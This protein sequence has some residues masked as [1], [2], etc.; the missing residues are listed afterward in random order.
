MVIACEFGVIACEFEVIAC[1]Y[2]GH[3]VL[4]EAKLSTALELVVHSPSS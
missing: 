1:E 4:I 2:G 3:R